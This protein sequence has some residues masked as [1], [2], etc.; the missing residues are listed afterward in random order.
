MNLRQLGY[1]L[2][3]AELRNFTHAAN[4]LFVSQPALS[5]Q[6]R[7]LEEELGT[8]LFIRSERGVKLTEAGDL[9]RQRSPAI[10]S[11]IAQLRNELQ[12]VYSQ[13][14][15]GSLAIG[16]GM[17][18]RGILTVPLITQYRKQY[19]DVSLHVREG[20]TSPLIEDV[21]LGV[22]D[23]ALVFELVP[24]E[25]VI[26][27]PFVRESLLLVGPPDAGL[28][29]DRPI[30]ARQALS[31]PL[32]VT[33]GDSPLRR[34][35]DAIAADLGTELP[36][37]FET[38]AVGVMIDCIAQGAY[39]AILPYSAASVAIDSQAVSAAP[40]DGQLIDWTFIYARSFGLSLPAKVL[41]DMLF[42]RTREMIDTGVWQMARR[43]FD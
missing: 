18:V 31:Q 37:A 33:S 16:M 6:M 19:P 13:A 28:R 5:R 17:S 34:K 29:L 27:E 3:I 38:N 35:T 8:A 23:C 15:S 41:R 42:T 40:I 36:V 4:A 24:Y 32:A 12:S 25:H 11:D 39:H 43:R 9:L 21:K 2:K 26:E 10:L 7:Q 1:F 20:I 22:L 14:P 30:T